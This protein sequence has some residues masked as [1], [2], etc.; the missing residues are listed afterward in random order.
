MKKEYLTPEIE[1]VQLSLRN[2]IL[3]LSYET[4]GKNNEEELNPGDYDLDDLP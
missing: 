4:S 3:E 1:C 2:D